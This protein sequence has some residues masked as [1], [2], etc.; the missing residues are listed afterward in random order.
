MS[1]KL[2]YIIISIICFL[3]GILLVSNLYAAKNYKKVVTPENNAVL[4]VEVSKLTKS[5]AELREQVKKL[6]TNLDTYK[7]KAE[8]EKNIIDQ[9]DKDTRNLDSINGALPQSGQ[10]VL[11]KIDSALNQ[12]QS[13]DLI[14]AIK[15]IGSVSIVINGERLVLN[16][17]LSKYSSMKPCEILVLGNST[18]LKSALQRKGGIIEQLSRENVKISVTD[19]EDITIPAGTPVQFI[20][21]KYIIN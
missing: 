9:F 21:S 13:I 3:A 5:N 11:I 19:D 2:D 1:K 4:A 17:Q 6:T 18:L 12:A 8:S 16:S 14:N 15:N 7:N 20:Y 10:G